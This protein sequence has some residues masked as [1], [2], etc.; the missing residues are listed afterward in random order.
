MGRKFVDVVND[1]RI[2]F[3]QWLDFFCDPVI[4]QRMKDSEIHH[5][6]PALAGVVKEL[7]E[8]PAFKDYLS[9]YDSHT[10]PRGRQAVGVIV[11]LVMESMGWEKTGRKGS[12]G[13][14][15]HVPPGTKSPG[16]YQNKSGMSKWFTKAERYQPPGGYPYFKL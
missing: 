12:L 9:N 3:Q 10:T 7:E 2:N 16:A 1:S 6:R 5:N 8:N 13:Q 14:R 15:K 11:C 4:Q